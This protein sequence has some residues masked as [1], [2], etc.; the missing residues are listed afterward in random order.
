[1]TIKHTLPPAGVLRRLAALLYDGLII[2]AIEMFAAGLIIAI[3][4]A[5]VALGIMTYGSYQGPSGLLSTHP[6]WSHVF[7][8]YLGV[9]W[10]G[11]FV[12]FWTKA[13]QTVGMR[14]WKLRVQNP[15]GSLISRT[16]ALIRIGTSIF[17]LANLLVPLDP[18]KRGFHDIW[19]KT[20]VV[21]LPKVL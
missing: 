9:I 1:M 17:G 15:D 5:F 6:F 2:L 7:T 11:F 8:I 19:A 4:E 10:V 16:Q 13:G 12:Y 21:V 20:E 18:Q 14:T 3:L